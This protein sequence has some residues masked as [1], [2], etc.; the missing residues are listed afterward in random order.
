MKNEKNEKVI[1]SLA[2]CLSGISS[3]II[4]SPLDVIKTRVMVQKNKHLKESLFNII[5]NMYKSEGIASFYQGL[6]NLILI[7]N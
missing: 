5:K 1:G 3:S 4:L 7:I 6:G 2:G